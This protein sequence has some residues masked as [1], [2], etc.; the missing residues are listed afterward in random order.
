MTMVFTTKHGDSYILSSTI[1][2]LNAKQGL[3]PNESSLPC[4]EV[5]SSIRTLPLTVKGNDDIS[6]HIDERLRCLYIVQSSMVVGA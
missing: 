1:A 6:Y 5:T 4:H 3:T 2:M